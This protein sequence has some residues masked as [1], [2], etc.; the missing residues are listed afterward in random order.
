MAYIPKSSLDGSDQFGRRASDD[1]WKLVEPGKHDISIDNRKK[2]MLKTIATDLVSTDDG[3]IGDTIMKNIVEPAVHHTLANT[4]DVLFNTIKD[5]IIALVCGPD[6]TPR[7]SKGGNSYVE[8][9]K[10]SRSGNNNYIPFDTRADRSYNSGVRGAPAD[11][12]SFYRNIKC[13]SRGEAESLLSDVRYYLQRWPTYR[14]SNLLSLIG[15][16]SSPNHVNWGWTADMLLLPDGSLNRRV[17]SIV[18]G[19]DETGPVWFVRFPD[20]VPMEA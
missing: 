17:V 4:I 16:V 8:Y 3:T 2:S 9:S 18:M 12:S 10:Y 1:Q 11:L 13:K 5:A 20:P 19:H 6:Y 7:V 15:Q 14:L